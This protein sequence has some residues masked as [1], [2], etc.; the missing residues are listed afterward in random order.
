MSVA[1][2]AVYGALMWSLGKVVTTPE[3]LRVYVGSFIDRE[4]Q[5]KDNKALFE[6]E[7]NDLL[8]DLRSLPRNASVRKINELVKRARCAKVHALIIQHMYEQFGFFSKQSTQD[9]MLGKLP[10]IFLA[11]HQKTGLPI[12]D[13]PN[14]QRFREGIQHFKIWEFPELKPKQ[15]AVM[16]DVRDSFVSLPRHAVA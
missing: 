4:Y 11:V 6:V 10:D 1:A 13:F 12:G 5:I 2:A 8:A 9:E 3:A 15:V 16:D 14:P 7:Q